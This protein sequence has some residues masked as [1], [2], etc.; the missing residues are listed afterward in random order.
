MAWYLGF[1]TNGPNLTSAIPGMTWLF[2]DSASSDQWGKS[3]PEMP[4]RLPLISLGLQLH[5]VEYAY[6]ESIAGKGDY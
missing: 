4:R 5:K 2:P 1:S 3:S 6:L